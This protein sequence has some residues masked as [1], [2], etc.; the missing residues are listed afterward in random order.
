MEQG[1]PNIFILTGAYDDQYL[2]ARRDRVHVC[3]SAGK[4]ITLYR[5][6]EQA[7][8]KPVVLLSPQPRGYENPQS[9]PATTSRFG[10]QIQLFA[11]ASGVRKIRFA[12]DML[13]Y[14][15]HVA[16][17]TRS[18]D[19]FIVDNYE[20][21]YVLAI[22][23]CRLLGR[24]NR[25]LLEYEDGKHLIDQGIWRQMSGLAEW[26]ARPWL[27]G[28]ILAT[29]ALGERLPPDIPK[30]LVPGIL[31]EEIV[32]NPPPAP[33]QP[34]A[35]LYSGSLDSERGGPLLLSYL[36]QGNFPTD[37]EIHITGQG[38]FTDRLLAVQHQFP[39]VVH[40]HGT[41]SQEELARI[42]S[43]CHF[44]LNLQSSSHPISTVTYPSKTFDYLNAGLRVIST[45]AAGVTGVLAAAAV[46]LDE[47]TPA[48]L[49]AIL[50]QTSESLRSDD[51]SRTG[52]I[53]RPFTYEGTVKRLCILFQPPSNR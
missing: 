35:F 38:H 27:Q 46:Y 12:L 18:G 15:R 16:S 44:G 31:S 53:G 7:A 3:T 25:I 17:H 33:G 14:A 5:A 32:F 24:R 29:P 28:A 11:K 52:N 48:A 13:H 45:R 23:Y 6:I 4:R 26:L 22:Q 49:A 51:G 34:V 2:Q 20:L 42:R 39:N 41:V 21:I 10:S 30:V 36:E 37:L 1:S 8:G 19:V 40:F 50:H 43:L 9:L 47:E